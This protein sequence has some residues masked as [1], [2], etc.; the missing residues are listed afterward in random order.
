MAG[1][2]TDPAIQQIFDDIKAFMGSA[3]SSCTT[4]TTISGTGTN[5]NMNCVAV[6]GGNWIYT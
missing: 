4:S 2:I 3:Y 1:P 6:D 5:Y